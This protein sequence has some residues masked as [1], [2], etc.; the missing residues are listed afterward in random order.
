MHPL[1]KIAVFQIAKARYR[2]SLGLWGQLLHLQ[3]IKF[4]RMLLYAEVAIF[5]PTTNP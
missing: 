4:E 3:R 1:R 2:I 5:N